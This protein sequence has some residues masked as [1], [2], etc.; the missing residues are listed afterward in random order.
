[1]LAFPREAEL[2]GADFGILVVVRV[3]RALKAVVE[4]QMEAFSAKNS[5][6]RSEKASNRTPPLQNEPVVQLS[7]GPA[8][9]GSTNPMTRDVRP[10][11]RLI[12]KQTRELHTYVAVS[13]KQGK[14][15]TFA[16]RI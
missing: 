11:A 10:A 7:K 15:T 16:S 8:V 13:A 4:R 1:M 5:S 3:K 6:S 14:A 12:L 2:R 9:T